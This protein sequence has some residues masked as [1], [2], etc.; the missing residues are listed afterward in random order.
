MS[1]APRRAVPGLTALLLLSLS[2]ARTPV[3]LHAGAE[4]QRTKEHVF[5]YPVSEALAATVEVLEAHDYTVEPFRD[6]RHLLTRW[7]RRGDRPPYVLS[8]YYVEGVEVSA[9]HSIIRIFHIR[10]N[11]TGFDADGDVEQEALI[12]AEQ[13]SQGQGVSD[14]ESSWREFVVAGSIKAEEGKDETADPDVQRRQSVAR[15]RNVGQRQALNPTFFNQYRMPS[16]AEL[17]GGNEHGERDAPMERA[18]VQRL[19]QFP[20]LEFSGGALDVPAPPAPSGALPHTVAWEAELGGMPFSAGEPCGQPVPGL[21]ALSAPLA[22][23]LVGEQLGSREAPA[24]VGNLA[25]QMASGGH[26]VLLGLGLPRDEQGL[27]DAYVRSA[28]TRAD[29]D[30]LLAGNFWRQVPRDGRS[31]RALVLLLDRARRWRASGLKVDVVAYDAPGTHH[32]AREDAVARLL[33]ARH[34][35]AP[36][37][38]LVVL[39]GNDHVRVKS[40]ASWFSRFEPVGLRLA[41]AGVPLKSVD[42]AFR[43]GTRWACSVHVQRDVPECRVFIAAPSEASYSPEDRKPGLELF[44]QRSSEGFD[45]LLHVGPLSA[46]LPALLPHTTPASAGTAAR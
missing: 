18:L 14:S 1:V 9:R 38:L 7:Q 40:G 10:K 43:R 26:P 29:Q 6:S 37:A 45:G 28:G 22:A 42:M 46:S 30:A 15:G 31:S 33:L 5:L 32:N 25:C 34:R 12:A 24:M 21:E 13:G 11:V 16:Q 4:A 19:E 36:D 39:G 8:R 2:C 23:L 3:P 17:R 35:A 20:S 44:A 27:V 41:R